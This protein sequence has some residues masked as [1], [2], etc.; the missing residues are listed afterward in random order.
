MRSF[1][2][3]SLV[4]K[5]AGFKIFLN[6]GLISNNARVIPKRI[7]P[8]CPVNPPPFTLTGKKWDKKLYYS[9]SGYAGGLTS[10][11]AKDVMAKFPTR[12]VEKAII[13][14]LPHTKLG[15]QMADKLFVYAGPD[16][17]HQAQQP[18]VMEV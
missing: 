8:A 14:M 4:I 6:S 9:H 7:A 18:K 1:E 15:R 5:P 17:K 12:M 10:T 13:G 16:H 11:T 3:G 2:R